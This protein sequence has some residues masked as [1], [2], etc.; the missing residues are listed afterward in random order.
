MKFRNLL[1]VL[2]HAVQNN[3]D[4]LRLTERTDV[5]G[6]VSSYEGKMALLF[7]VRNCQFKIVS[8]MVSPTIVPS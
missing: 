2:R 7:A 3:N 4:G 5:I 8:S 6:A 1:E